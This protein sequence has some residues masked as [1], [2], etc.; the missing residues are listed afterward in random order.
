MVNGAA[1]SKTFQILYRNE[2]VTLN[3]VIL[4]KAHVVVDSKKVIF[5]FYLFQSF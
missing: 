2:E 5:I 1:V 4:F 3:D